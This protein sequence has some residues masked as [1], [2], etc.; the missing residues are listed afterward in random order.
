MARMLAR[1]GIA[2]AVIDYR[3]AP[4]VSLSEIVREDYKP[5]KRTSPADRRGANVTYSVHCL[6][7]HSSSMMTS[8]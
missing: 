4:A 5:D 8:Y 7:P 3:L 1:Y 2:T 6:M